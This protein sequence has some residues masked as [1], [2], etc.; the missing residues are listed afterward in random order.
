MGPKKTDKGKGRAPDPKMPSPPKANPQKRGASGSPQGASPRPGQVPAPQRQATT[1]SAVPASSSQSRLSVRDLLNPSSRPRSGVHDLLHPKS[2]SPAAGQP[3]APQVQRQSSISS[4]RSTGSASSLTSR[5]PPPFLAQASLQN[6]PQAGPPAGQ[7]AP[8]RQGAGRDLRSTPPPKKGGAP[9]SAILSGP[10]RANSPRPTAMT[11]PPRQNTGGSAAPARQQVAPFSRDLGPPAAPIQTQNTGGSVRSKTS[12]SGLTPS[13][14]GSK[15]GFVASRQNPCTPANMGY[16]PDPSVSS[17]AKGKG[18]AT[19]PP[20]GPSYPW[21]ARYEQVHKKKGI[22]PHEKVWYCS[23]CLRNKRSLQFNL[24]SETCTFN[25]DRKLCGTRYSKEDGC[26]M[27]E[28][29]QRPP[30]YLN[31]HMPNITRLGGALPWAV[32]EGPWKSYE[33]F[34]NLPPLDSSRRFLP[35]WYCC[36]CKNKKNDA[37]NVPNYTD[38]CK[39]PKPAR[40]RIECLH[41]RCSKCKKEPWKSGE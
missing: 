16:N 28:A 24:M 6:P 29:W 7:P 25:E 37:L 2:P 32:N 41:K 39:N 34:R 38:Y 8:Q 18:R 4:L 31:T 27:Q 3:P 40:R 13:G 15:G 20:S 22:S 5:P 36:D 21:G 14:S 26:V 1:G 12:A 30:D 17:S 35:A 9:L 11:P 23:R 19:T 33:Y 10:S